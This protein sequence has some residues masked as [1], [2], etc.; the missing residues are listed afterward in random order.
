MQKEGDAGD[1]VS[2]IL[3]PAVLSFGFARNCLHNFVCFAQFCACLQTLVVFLPNFVCLYAFF[4]HIFGANFSNLKLCQCFF[5][6]F[7]QHCTRDIGLVQYR[8]FR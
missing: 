5:S 1:A 3:F 6:N 4:A 7:L 8:K 2:A